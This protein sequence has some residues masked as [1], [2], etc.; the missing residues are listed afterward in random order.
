[1]AI[2]NV[3]NGASATDRG[4]KILKQGDDL[5]KNA[6]LKILSAELSNQDPSKDMDSTEYVSQMAQFA[7]M[8]QLSNL[9]ATMSTYASQ[10]LVGKGVTVGIADEKGNPYTGVVKGV[11]TSA[12]GTKI[13]VEVNVDGKNVYKDFD[14]KDVVTVI[15]V[16]DYALPPLNNMN[17][18]MSFLVASSFLN[19]E[20]ELS[21][22]DEDDNALKGVVKGVYKDKGEIKVRIE[23]ESGE[24]KEYSY[25]KI[26]KVGD[27]S[28]EV[29]PDKPT[30]DDSKE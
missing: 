22:K 18:N 1:M 24:I 25:E 10:N 26:V 8:E 29:T 16:P 27:F 20:V 13:S 21:E 5:D 17:G 6:F 2:N 28:E 30:E 9:N 11:T 12:A 15:E 7:S 23:L 14:I 4:T 19:K 3:Y